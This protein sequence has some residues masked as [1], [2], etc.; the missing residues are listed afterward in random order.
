MPRNNATRASALP[1]VTALFHVP[2]DLQV[3]S[4]HIYI[5]TS[6]HAASRISKLWVY[7]FSSLGRARARVCVCGIRSFIPRCAMRRRF[8]Y[9]RHN[10][11]V[12]ADIASREGEKS[13]ASGVIHFCLVLRFR[14]ICVFSRRE[15]QGCC[16]LKMHEATMDYSSIR[17][18]NI[19]VTN[20]TCKL[21]MLYT[22][23]HVEDY[24][25]RHS[26]WIERLLLVL[27][28]LSFLI[29]M[30]SFVRLSYR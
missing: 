24:F 12:A 4:M 15:S 16:C 20:L 28:F 22:W 5:Y 13:T 30:K 19:Y 14:L 1:S 23:R 7:I 29:F 6:I 2:S 10:A 27:S 3:S 25:N 21:P 17:L 11:K 8:S 9:R 26:R 18:N